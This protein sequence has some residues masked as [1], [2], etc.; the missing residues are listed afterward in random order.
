MQNVLLKHI[1]LEKNTLEVA[2]VKNDVQAMYGNLNNL[3]KYH[4]EN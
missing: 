3:Q 1:F 4:Y 2:R